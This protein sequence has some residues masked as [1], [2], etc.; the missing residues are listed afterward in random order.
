LKQ[1][2]FILLISFLIQLSIYK[3]Q[4]YRHYQSKSVMLIR[5]RWQKKHVFGSEDLPAEASAQAGTVCRD[6]LPNSCFCGLA[7][8]IFFLFQI[9]N[10]IT[11]VS[12]FGL[13]TTSV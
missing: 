10:H 9:C 13:R 8:S 12:F 1:T 7:F 5:V 2:H 6:G 11:A 3:I 4:F